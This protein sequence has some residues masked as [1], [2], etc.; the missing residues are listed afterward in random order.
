[1]SNEKCCGCVHRSV[2]VGDT[3]ESV[4]LHG[5]GCQESI[6][7]QRVILGAHGEAGV[8]QQLQAP[9]KTFTRSEVLAVLRAKRATVDRKSDALVAYNDLIITF[10]QME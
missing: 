4:V 5:A 10:E 2:P 3:G 7:S 1:M 6:G 8:A 9:G